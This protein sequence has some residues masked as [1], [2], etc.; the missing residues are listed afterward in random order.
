[1]YEPIQNKNNYQYIVEQIKQMILDE[2]LSVGDRLPSER[3][4]AEMYQVSRASVREALKALETLGLLEC[5]HGGGNYIVNNLK[6][7]MSDN[8]SLVFV[9]DHCTMTDLTNLRYT[10]EMETIRSIIRK[11]DPEVKKHLLALVDRINTAKDIKEFEQIDLDFHTLIASLAAN[12]LMQY[13]QSSIHTVYLR[14][15]QFLNESYP[16]WPDW[17]NASLEQSREYQLEIL[18]A[19]LSEDI[20]A[21]EKALA[22]HYSC[23]NDSN[24]DIESIYNKYR[25][26]KKEQK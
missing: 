26:K 19:V 18:N 2:E 16:Y 13:L 1:M 9:L 23:Y 22:A 17:E 3:D 20:Y 11:K 14:N 6:E 8:L 15:I 25:Q 24:L 10:F 7:Q 21:I 5:R 4:L 12:P